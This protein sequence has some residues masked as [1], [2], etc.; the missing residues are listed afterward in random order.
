MKR[1]S[2]H[3]NLK[4]IGNIFKPIYL[5]FDKF[6]ITEIRFESNLNLEYF[7]KHKFDEIFDNIKNNFSYYNKIDDTKK[8][9][10]SISF[11]LK[12]DYDKNIFLIEIKPIEF[13]SA[14]SFGNLDFTIG[15][16]YQIEDRLVNLQNII[17]D[18]E[19]DNVLE[20]SDGTKLD[21]S[22]GNYSWM[23]NNIKQ[24]KEQL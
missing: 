22:S 17:L 20:F 3:L 9:L 16:Q 15:K 11:N 13:V 18:P 10:I 5:D 7:Y 19:D 2:L 12:S 23:K 14:I 1:F 4:N 24:I 21:I 8:G 6:E